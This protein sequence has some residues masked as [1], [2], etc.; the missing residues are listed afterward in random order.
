MAKQKI[1]DEGILTDINVVLQG[2]LKIDHEEV[3]NFIGC[4][5]LGD[6]LRK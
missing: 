5:N 4:H 3:C 1:K 2:N 6:C